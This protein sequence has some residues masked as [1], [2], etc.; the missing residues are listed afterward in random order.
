MKIGRPRLRS[1]LLMVNLVVLLL[2]LGGIAVFRL[3]ETE[4][5]K[6]T[7]ASLIGQGT[8]VASMFRVEMARQFDLA[9]DQGEAFDLAYG[10]ALD[11]RF[12]PRERDVYDPIPPQAGYCP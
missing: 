9:L 4:L 5:V 12:T 6:Q 11:P 1:I 10:N 3:Y 8:L 2:P 7:E